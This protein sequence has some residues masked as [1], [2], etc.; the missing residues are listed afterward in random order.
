MSPDAPLEQLEPYIRSRLHPLAEYD[1]AVAR[2]TSDYDLNEGAMRPLAGAL[3]PAAVLVPLIERPEGLSVLLTRRADSLR[4][5]SGQVAFPGG[6]CEPGETPWD[7]ALREAEEEV[8]LDR[9]LVRVAGLAD[10][11][12]TVTGFCITP[13]VGF[14]RPDLSLTLCAAEVAEAFEAPFAWLMDP[15]RHEQRSARVGG[16]DRRYY[17]MPYGEH[18]IWGATAGMLRALWRRLFG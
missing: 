13:V 16:L 9:R 5:H 14:V 7:T 4:R 18:F 12:E 10:R 11:Y 6:R 2:M 8:G 15:E 17:A 3:A 1:P